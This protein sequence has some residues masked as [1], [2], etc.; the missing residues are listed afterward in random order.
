MC[1][2]IFLFEPKLNIFLVPH[3]WV[4]CSGKIPIFFFVLL[5]FGWIV[6]YVFFSFFFS[7]VNYMIKNCRKFTHEEYDFDLMTR[8]RKEAV[9][10][11]QNCHMFGLIQGSLGRQGNPKI[12]EVNI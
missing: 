7:F 6:Y 8:K 1:S 10:I 9:E 3:F 5:D 2:L 11:A 12:V 4:E